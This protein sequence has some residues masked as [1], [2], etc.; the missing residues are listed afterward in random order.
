MA[1]VLRVQHERQKS[2]SVVAPGVTAIWVASVAGPA[3][4]ATSDAS[5]VDDLIAGLFIVGTAVFFSP[6]FIAFYRNHPYRWVIFGLCV[7]AGWTALGWVAAFA[8]SV[9]P[10]Q[11]PFSGQLKLD[12]TLS[13]PAESRLEQLERLGKLRASSDLTQAEFD[14]EKSRILRS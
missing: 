2:F 14:A 10:N 12:A 8:W 13:A 11:R 6:C 1:T 9:W 7:V 3:F 5:S 4:A